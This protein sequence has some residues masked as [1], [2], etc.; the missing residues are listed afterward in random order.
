MRYACLIP[1]KA[2]RIGGSQVGDV[3]RAVCGHVGGPRQ[4]GFDGGGIAYAVGAAVFGELM[5]MDG[6]D[7]FRAGDPSPRPRRIAHLASALST[8]RSLRMIFSARANCLVAS[9]GP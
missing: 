7:D 8:S 4:R 5:L 2:E 1:R 6:K 9:D 3:G